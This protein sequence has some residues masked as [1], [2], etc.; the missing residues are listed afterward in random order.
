MRTRVIE[1]KA[2]IKEDLKRSYGTYTAGSN[3]PIKELF[4][5]KVTLDLNGEL[6]DIPM[7]K[8]E[9]F[10]DSYAIETLD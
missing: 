8:V 10:E 4:P 7:D 3:F 5:N 2:R 1:T 6:F 9:L